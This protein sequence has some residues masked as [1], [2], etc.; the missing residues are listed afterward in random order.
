MPSG[1]AI[2]R[3]RMQSCPTY[4]RVLGRMSLAPKAVHVRVGA[5]FWDG[6]VGVRTGRAFMLTGR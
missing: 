4:V 1:Q 2:Q 5:I 6:A 3:R